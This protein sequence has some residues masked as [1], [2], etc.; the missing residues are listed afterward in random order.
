M[1]S[2][3]IET[4]RVLKRRRGETQGKKRREKEK[5]KLFAS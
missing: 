2:K 1:Q 3:R 5:K 4:T